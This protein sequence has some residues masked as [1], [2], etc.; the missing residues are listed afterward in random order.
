M[1]LPAPFSHSE[2][3]SRLAALREHM[4]RAG[5]D[6]L[7]VDQFEHFSYFGGHLPTA[8]IYQCLLV[9]LSGEPVAVIRGLDAQVFHET[10][11]LSGY[12][13]FG[14]AEDPVRVA[15][16]ELRRMRLASARIGYE[17]DSNI[18]TPDRL[19]AFRAA[20]PEATLISFA[21][22]MWEMRQ[23]KSP[24]EIACLQKAAE[25]C[26]RATLAGFAA[27]RAGVSERDVTAAITTEALRAGA[28][29]TRLVLMASGPRSAALHGALGNRT[30]AQ[31]DLLHVEMV[32]H[33]RGYTARIMRPKSIGT[34]TDEQLRISQTMIEIQ[35]RQY[36]AM[37][38]GAVAKDVDAVLRE[39]I[40]DAG[41]R[42]EYSNVTGYTLGLVYIPRTSDFTRVFHA[43][44]SWVLEENTV[45]HMYTWAG[46]MA[47]SDTVLVTPSGGRRMTQCARMLVC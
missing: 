32:P 3:Q 41:L 16:A 22:V 45:F 25:I 38:P 7:I 29:N 24:S 37:R 47:F 34:P 39:G 10:S 27:A 43:E 19:E 21:G 20:L 17:G 26:D 28:D 15:A 23:V 1:T 44:S 36:A 40:L 2:Y 4:H 5:L 46:G 14:D 31:G 30:L 18:L 42:E 9:P 11:W 12:R 8:A 6:G 33:F 35:D 13:A